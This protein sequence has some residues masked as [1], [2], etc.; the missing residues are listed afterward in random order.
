[1]RLS[2]I[3]VAQAQEVGN[4]PMEKIGDPQPGFDYAHATCAACTSP[5][6][7]KNEKKIAIKKG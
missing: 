3:A 6:A 7:Q 2:A 1:M 4:V 5:E